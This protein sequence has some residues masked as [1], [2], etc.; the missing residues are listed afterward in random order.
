MVDFAKNH[1]TQVPRQEVQRAL[2]GGGSSARVETSTLVAT[3]TVPGASIDVDFDRRLRGANRPPHRPAE[4]HDPRRRSAAA[5]GSAASLPA[6]PRCRRHNQPHAAAKCR[7]RVAPH[8]RD[9]STPAITHDAKLLAAQR[10]GR[11]VY[12]CQ[13]PLSRHLRPQLDAPLTVRL[14]IAEFHAP[15]RPVEQRRGD[16]VVAGFGKTGRT[17]CACGGS[18]RKSPAPTT[19]PARRVRRASLV[20]AQPMTVGRRQLDHASH[21][22][23]PR[24]FRGP[25]LPWPRRLCGM[26]GVWARSSTSGM[27][28]RPRRRPPP[29]PPPPPTAPWHG[30]TPAERDQQRLEEEQARRKLDGAKQEP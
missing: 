4:C 27:R 29:P 14:A 23:T 24:R 19:R 9:G 3:K 22:C 7:V 16:D 26:V 30:R 12:V 8:P 5:P 18:R 28:A 17:R 21:F 15:L 10:L 11:C 13:R 1:P 20:R 6:W 2:I 25:L